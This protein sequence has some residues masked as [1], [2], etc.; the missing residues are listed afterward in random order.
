VG[1][2][3]NP[4]PKD[5]GW[6]GPL[7]PAGPCRWRIPPSYN[8]GMRVGGLIYASDKLVEQ[9]RKDRA[10]EQ[11][12][13]VACLPG[14]VGASMAMPDIH[15]GYGFPIGGVAATDPA[16]GGVIS[17]GGVGYDINCGV[18][19]IRTDLEHADVRSRMRQLV[20]SLFSH[21]PCGVGRQSPIRFSEPETLELMKTGSPWIVKKG[22]GTS[23]DAEH[24]EGRGCLHDADPESVSPRARQRGMGQVGTLG[25]GNHFAEI[26]RVDTVYDEPAAEAMGLFPGQVAV[27]LHTGSRGL[28]YQVCEDNL[29]ATQKAVRKYGYQ[30]PDRQLGCA[31]V[32][33]EEG[34]RYLRAMR[35]AANYAWANR[36]LL[37]HF[38]RQA[39]SEV[40]G[41]SWESLG[42]ELVYDVAHN[43]A[44]METYEIGGRRRTLCIHRKGATRAFGPGHP[45][46][47]ADYRDVGQPV[48]IPGDMGTASYVLVGTEQAMT[49]SF[50]STCHG[51]GRVMSRAAAKRAMHGKEVQ[52]R[53]E[54]RGI[55]VRGQSQAGLAEE[56]PDAYKDVDMVVETVHRAGLSR[57]VARLV[58]L[59]VIKG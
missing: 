49:E 36:Q 16:E 30:L 9:I 51:A 19:L 1:R 52:R 10:L 12:A 42:M 6:Y 3:K 27:M 55:I 43:I 59:G 39:F 34:R 25:G 56:Q 41:R 54:Q 20:D 31:P 13:N 32:H 48:L 24:T 53:L 2:Q 11:V 33:S 5:R 29:V 45:D 21:I 17:P 58:P 23:R 7:E 57:K 8:P 26:Q 4:P 14:I 37:T 18:R 47:P 28:G 22:Y 50:G 40:L 44:K 15:W 35:S 46:L 38:I